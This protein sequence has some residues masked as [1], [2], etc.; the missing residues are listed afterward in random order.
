MG[1]VIGT[2]QITFFDRT[3]SGGQHIAADITIRLLRPYHRS[4]LSVV[5][6]RSGQPSASIPTIIACFDSRSEV[7]GEILCVFTTR[8]LF[9]DFSVPDVVEIS[10]VPII[11]DVDGIAADIKSI[12]V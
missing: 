10:A 1:L 6:T 3:D 5:Q 4:S 7:L 8:Q 9:D 11:G 12:I 2:T